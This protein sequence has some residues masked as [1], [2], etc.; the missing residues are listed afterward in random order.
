MKEKSSEINKNAPKAQK[1][2]TK[3]KEGY[4]FDGFRCVVCVKGEKVMSW[5]PRV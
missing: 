5:H 1:R 4:D 3:Q 2:S